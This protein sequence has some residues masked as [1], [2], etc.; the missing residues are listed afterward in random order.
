[1]ADSWS[2]LPD[3]DKKPYL[4]A[5]EIDKERYNKELAVINLQKL[6]NPPE[7]DVQNDKTCSKS[8]TETLPKNFTVPTIVKIE[9]CNGERKNSNE[10]AIFTEDFLDHNKTAEQEL[11]ILRKSTIDYEQQNSVLEKH[12]ENMSNGV[13]KLQNEI[14]NTKLS[15]QSMEAYLVKLRGTLSAALNDGGKIENV[16]KY[17]GDLHSIIKTQNLTPAS[18]I[19]LN[20]CREKLAKNWT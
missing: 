19:K 16:D 14:V 12:I 9:K 13:D 7:P 2:K 20:K 5:A 18:L 11:R 6:N 15:T 10:I 1:M 8:K 17:L 4:A 3:E